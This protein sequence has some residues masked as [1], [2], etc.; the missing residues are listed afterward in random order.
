MEIRQYLKSDD[1][2]LFEMMKA[3]GV[4]WSEYYSEKNIDRY[5]KA[6][7][8]SIVFVAWNGEK[9]C[10]YVRARDDEGFGVYIYDLLVRKSFRGNSLGYKLIKKVCEKYPNDNIYVMSDV[11]EYYEKQDFRREGS[12]FQ[13]QY[14]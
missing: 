10:G 12:I 7:S 1:T 9:I 14:K 8:S 3:E 11:D 13:I 5:K 2:S 4:D 6:L